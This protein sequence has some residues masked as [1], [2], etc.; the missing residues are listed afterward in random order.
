MM[1]RKKFG[2]AMIVATLICNTASTCAVET[3][4]PASASEQSKSK[5]QAQT[6][7]PTPIGEDKLE[8]KG[9]G[10]IKELA[11]GGY[12]SIR[13]SFII[14]AR[15]AQTYALLKELNERLPEFG[16]DFFKSNAV[17]AAFLGQRRSGGYSVRI[18]REGD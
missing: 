13:E 10:E 17:I 5:P 2:L 4:A 8:A 14:V 6:P 1:T 18:T 11:A 9:S 12:S 3:R 15:D 7:A 16:A